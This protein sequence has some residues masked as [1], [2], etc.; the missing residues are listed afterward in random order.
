MDCSEESR[1]GI[2]IKKGGFRR[3]P[4]PVFSASDPLRSLSHLA[5]HAV[6]QILP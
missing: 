5:D 2:Q 4:L 1:I 6:R 3:P